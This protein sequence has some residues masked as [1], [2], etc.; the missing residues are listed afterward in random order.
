MN[1]VVINK[2]ITSKRLSTYNNLDGYELNLKQSKEYYI[3]L[4]ILEIALRNS[5]N[6]LFIKFY[7]AGWLVGGAQF[8]QGDLLAKIADAKEKLNSRNENITKDKLVAELSF[9]FWTA[10]FQSPYKHQ[11]RLSDL[12]QIFPNLP[13]KEDYFI[14]RK[15]MS[16]KL[17]HI[18]KFRNRIFHYEKIVGK[19]EYDSIEADIYE[20]LGYFDNEIGA[21]SER[22]NDE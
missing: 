8:L 22:L 6:T 17:D 21:F 2:F 13:K 1:E 3:P 18:R 12:K 7:G 16:S 4:A 19:S 15:I 20:I 10:L 11:M 9:G 5:I 14:D